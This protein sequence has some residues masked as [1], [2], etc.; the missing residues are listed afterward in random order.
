MA[1]PMALI[2]GASRGI[3]AAFAQEFVAAGY[4]LVLVARSRDSLQQLAADLTSEF[5]IEAKV[6]VQDLTVSNA[7]EL[8]YRQVQA[9]NR[10]IDV[11]VNN[12]G[13]GAYGDLAD[14]DRQQ[15]LNMIQLNVMALVDLT[16][17]CLG[18]MRSR[19][20]GAIINIAS[21]AAYQAMPYL[22]VY[23]ATKAFVLSFSEALWAENQPTG[24]RVLAVCPGPTE[25][26]FFQGAKFPDKLVSQ[27][28]QI[29]LTPEQVAREA[30]ASLD[31]N[32]SNLV[33][34]NLL[35]KLLI[36][37]PRLLPREAIVGQVAQQFRP[38]SPSD[39]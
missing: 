19:G 39:P 33:P 8:V 15:Q 30:I 27:V 25:T 10:P 24:V 36:N 23:G 11:L 31:G 32:A 12:A 38:P 6:I 18:D 29:Y 17:W 7:A 2:T 21:T 3:G 4:N 28:E 13:F 1:R 5:R 35:N 9:A 20:Q 34:G 16:Y 22:A 26:Q 37:L 14:L